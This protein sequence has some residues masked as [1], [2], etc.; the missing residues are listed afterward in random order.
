MALNAGA[1]VVGLLPGGRPGHVFQ[2]GVTM[3]SSDVVA[4]PNAAGAPRAIRLFDLINVPLL[5]L[6]G[7][8][9]FLPLVELE[10]A[11]QRFEFNG[12]NLATG[13]MPDELEAM[14]EQGDRSSGEGMKASVF[15]LLIPIFAFTA[16]GLTV[17][18]I[19]QK[20]TIEP[21]S[22]PVYLASA[23]FL[24]LLFYTLFGFALERQVSSEMAEARRKGEPVIVDTDKTGWFYASLLFSAGACGLFAAGRY[25]PRVNPDILAG[26]PIG[27]DGSGGSG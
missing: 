2:T 14:A 9:F 24:L 18:A 4:A 13:S 15:A 17:R 22:P 11:G 16:A 12:W 3:D 7:L 23:L 10:C 20:R 5:A 8:M 26:V 19:Y 25:S 1:R 27:G 6:V 21:K